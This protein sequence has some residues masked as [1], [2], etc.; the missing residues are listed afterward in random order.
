MAKRIKPQPVKTKD[1]AL[2]I[3]DDIA[4]A[5]IALRAKSA[6]YAERMLE[7]QETVGREVDVMKDAIAAL[8][9]RV[10]PYIEKYGDAELFKA[11][12]RE[13]ETAIARFGVRLGNP[14]VTKDRK[15]TWDALAAEL[16]NTLPRFVTT[17]IA[18]N[19]AEI[20]NAWRVKDGDWENVHGTYGVDVVQTDS[21]WVEAKGEDVSDDGA[22]KKN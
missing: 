22:Q 7:L 16:N 12:Q 6:E 11:G 18:P 14:T 21:A 4:R 9:E 3:I 5:Q 10:A 20:L 17:K 1:E 2:E 19:K 8:I 15:W 13:G